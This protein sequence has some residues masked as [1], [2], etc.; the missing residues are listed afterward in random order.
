MNADGVEVEDHAAAIGKRAHDGDELQVEILAPD[1]K[2]GDEEIV[3]TGDERG[4]QQ[5]LG[6]RA[7][8]SRR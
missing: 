3:E 6:L 1:V 8:A 5:Q 4:L 7:A 2:G